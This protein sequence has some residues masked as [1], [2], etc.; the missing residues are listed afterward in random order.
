M[1]KVGCRTSDWGLGNRKPL[2]YS[3]FGVRYSKLEKKPGC[4]LPANPVRL[5][6][7][8]YPRTFV[9]SYAL[10]RVDPPP[11]PA[12]GETALRYA[13]CTFPAASCQLVV[14]LPAASCFLP[15]AYC[16]LPAPAG[17]PHPFSVGLD[18]TFNLHAPCQAP[19]CGLKQ[20]WS[21]YRRSL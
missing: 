6:S 12:M 2:R 17:P 7:P 1:M 4:Q 9:H 16:L 21:N 19:G 5:L 15:P 8:P 13:L 14:E 18:Y 20:R 3:E 11:N 10:T